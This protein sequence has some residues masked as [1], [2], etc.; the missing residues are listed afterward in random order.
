MISDR[1]VRG[2]LV[3]DAIGLLSQLDHRLVRET[4]GILQLDSSNSRAGLLMK[5]FLMKGLSDY[6]NASLTSTFH[7]RKHLT[8]A[9]TA[10]SRTGAH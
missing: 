8:L 7:I 10:I 1:S 9:T 2:H 4:Q 5:I 6:S 3:I